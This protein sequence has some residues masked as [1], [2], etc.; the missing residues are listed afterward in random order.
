MVAEPVLKILKV[1]TKEWD[2]QP[3][4]EMFGRWEECAS[5][6]ARAIDE[7]KPRAEMD[8]YM[9]RAQLHL[10]MHSSMSFKTR[11]GLIGRAPGCEVNQKATKCRRNVVGRNR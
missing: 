6:L 10:K 9:S 7:H 8:W 5:W 11:G 2:Y 4:P 1:M 3:T